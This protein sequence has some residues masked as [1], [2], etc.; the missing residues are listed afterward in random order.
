MLIYF[1]LLTI[2]LSI[3]IFKSEAKQLAFNSALNI[4][5]HGIESSNN[6]P[7][8][9]A[10]DPESECIY[11]EKSQFKSYRPKLFE[12]LRKIEGIENNEYQNSLNSC[13]L[14]EIKSDSKSGQAFLKSNNGLIVLKTLNRHE[15]KKLRKLLNA[16][17][18]HKFTGKSCIAGVLGL[19]RIKL[20]CGKKHYF[21][22]S[23]CVYPNNYISSKIEKFDLKGSMVGRRAA[24][25]SD[26]II[27]CLFN[28]NH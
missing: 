26:V 3:E 23:R 28:Y 5:F 7:T 16:Y 15:C 21:L 22:A 17:A 11:I 6:H 20:K 2:A 10:H 1:L 24:V 27:F 12:K 14:S 9:H 8:L 19:Y 13:N 25:N 4:L 18:L